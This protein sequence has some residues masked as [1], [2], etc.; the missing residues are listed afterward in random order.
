MSSE[1]KVL[2]IAEVSANH[3]GSLDRAKEIVRQ[4]ALSGATAVKFQTYTADTM[5]LKINDFSVSSEHQLWGGKNL[6]EL[7]REAYTPW[8]WHA[9]LFA[10]CRALNVIPFSSPFDSTAVDFLESLEAP[11]YKI[12]SLETSDHALIRKVASTGKP[13][14]ISTGATEWDEVA[15][16]VEVF[17]DSG[18]TD[19]TLLVCTSSYPADPADAHIARMK[20]LRDAFNVKVGLSDHTLGIG[21]SIAAIA[22]GATAIEKHITI[23]RSDG[24][25]D[26]AF[27]MEP[28][29]FT[30]LVVQGNFAFQSIGS[31]EWAINDSEKESRRL[32]RSLYVVKDVCIGDLAT[33]ENVRAIRPGYGASPSILSNI[34]GKKFAQDCNKGTP[35]DSSMVE[36]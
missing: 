35:F 7:Y 22:L 34:L 4:A 20:T 16:L 18:N 9:E 30:E 33:I 29:E 10:R 15:S 21:V 11:M 12:A 3:L 2:F 6:Y 27:S 8:D 26:S 36:N 32:R 17:K 1:S 25:A 23:K 31:A 5:T 19:L 24:G 28:H 13:V 14:I